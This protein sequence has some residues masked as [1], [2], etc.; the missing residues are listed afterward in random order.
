MGRV[1]HIEMIKSIYGRTRAVIEFKENMYNKGILEETWCLPFKDHLLVRMIAGVN[2]YELLHT[3][4]KFS[5][6]LLDL[7]ES[8]NEV[9]LQRQV[10]RSNTKAL[11]IFK[12]TN[13]NKMRS[14]TVYFETEEDLVSSLKFM[15]Y[16]NNNKL[17]WAREEVENAEFR[18]KK[19]V[20]KQESI[21][22]RS[23]KSLGK[24]R[25]IEI[26]PKRECSKHAQSF[27]Q[28]KIANTPESENTRTREVLEE[29]QNWKGSNN[30]EMSDSEEEVREAIVKPSFLKTRR[31]RSSMKMDANFSNQWKSQ[32]AS[33]TYITQQLRSLEEKLTNIGTQSANRS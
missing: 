7:P 13:D 23:D 29:K 3:R 18:S 5:T 2:E 21:L 10:K 28:I 15:I 25:E 24:R 32:E 30:F 9:L 26:D 33:L 11:H 4:N 19:K 12:N 20:K 1:E 31:N 14:A 17:R 6:R 16:Y 8:T 22:R 27:N